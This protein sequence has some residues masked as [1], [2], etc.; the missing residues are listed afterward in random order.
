VASASRGDD[1]RGIASCMYSAGVQS[2]LSSCPARSSDGL[3]G[4]TGLATNDEMPITRCP[5]GTIIVRQAPLSNY[6]S[7]AFACPCCPPSTSSS[8]STTT[9]SLSS[10][11]L[12]SAGS[13]LTPRRDRQPSQIGA[14]LNISAILISTASHS[15]R[16]NPHC[17]C[18][19]AT[20]VLT[21]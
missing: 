3:T 2:W 1:G 17:T 4:G 12:L 21:S 9:I 19:L 5:S 11:R 7:R 10:P 13:P 16:H 18:P 20:Y 14:N 6:S 8:S 15:C